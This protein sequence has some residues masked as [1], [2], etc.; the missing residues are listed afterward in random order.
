MIISYQ[1]LLDFLPVHV[2]IDDLSVILTSIGLEVEHVELSEKYKGGFKD[3]VVGHVLTCD[4]HPNADRLKVTTVDI[5]ERT[6]QIVCGAS[7]VAVGQKVIVAIPGAT[8]YPTNGESFTI[9][10]S[11]IRGIESEGM[12]C[13]ED[14]IGLGD[15]HEGIIVL[16]D[17]TLVGTLASE[18]YKIPAS[19]FAIHIGLTPNRSDANSHLGVAMDVCAYLSYHRKKDYK[20]QLKELLLPEHSDSTFMTINVLD[21]KACPRYAG[22]LLEGVKVMDSPQWL[23]D[24]LS[25]IGIRSINNIVDITN[26][27]LHETGQPLHAFDA[28]HIHEHTLNIGFA[29]EGTTFKTLDGRIR[30]LTSHD[31]MIQDPN[32]PFAMAGVFGGEDSSVTSVTTSIFIESAYFDPATIRRTSL[33]TGLRTDAATHFEKGVDIDRIIYAMNRAALLVIDVCGGTIISTIDEYAEVMKKN[34]ISVRYDFI[35]TLSGKE[36]STDQID[37]ILNSLGFIKL[38]ETNGSFVVEVPSYKIDILGQADIVEEVVRIDGLDNIAIPDKLN[39]SLRKPVI[40]DRQLREKAANILCSMGLHETVTNSITNSSYYPQEGDVVTMIN[41]LSSELNAMRPSML[42]SGLDVLA[43]NINRQQSDIATFEI[44]KIYKKS[45]SHYNESTRLAIYQ[46]GDL[47]SKNWMQKDTK[48]SIYSLG[49]IVD[50]LLSYFGIDK[51][52]CNYDTDSYSIIYSIK[53][54]ELATLQKVSKERLDLF[55]IKNDVFY[56]DIDWELFV[57][58]AWQV[59][60]RYYEVPKYPLISRSLSLVVDSTVTYNDIDAATKVLDLAML[61]DYSLFDVFESEKLGA[62]KKALALNYFFQSPDRTLTDDEIDKAMEQLS[63]NYRTSVG[64]L[65]RK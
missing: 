41:N 26:Y 28:A 21:K 42:E 31:L 12:I 1:W 45:G 34:Q 2:P 10:N 57:K 32:G 62:G 38:N 64:A 15:S 35:N 27:V 3:L 59:K 47:I 6:L 50:A 18:F 8:L 19:D 54:V 48:T 24:R 11:K 55:D 17:S 4:K 13:A 16:P 14:E 9:K 39:I 30:T 25:T 36:Y 22:V 61:K 63:S 65:I 37:T 53:G 33:E 7:N 20:V 49:G 5:G 23:K 58:E 29:K 40:S 44:G 51:Y 43:Y 52:S 56:A 46:T 60:V